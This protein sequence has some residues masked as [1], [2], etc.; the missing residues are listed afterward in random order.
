MAFEMEIYPA[1]GVLGMS[2]AGEFCDVVFTTLFF[3]ET[4]MDSRQPKSCGQRSLDQHLEV[5]MFEFIRNQARRIQQQRHIKRGARARQK[6][7][8]MSIESLEGRQLLSAAHLGHRGRLVHELQFSELPSAIQAGLT[9]D[10]S[11]HSVA[12]PVDTDDVIL[13]NANGVETYS[14]VVNSTGA[15]TRLTVDQDGAEVT[16][17]TTST[18]TYA[19]LKTSDATAA[20]EI[21]SIATAKNLTAPA[22]GKTVFVVTKSDGSVTYSMRLTRTATSKHKARKILVSVDAD[23]NPVGNQDVPF[24]VLSSTIQAG[25]NANLPTGATALAA[26][27]TQDVSVQTIDGITLYTTN[28][29]VDSTTTPVTVK[30]DGSV[31]ALPTH[32]TTTYA[33]LTTSDATAATEIQTLATAEGAGTIDTTSTVD[34]YTEATGT[35]LYSVTVTANDATTTNTYDLTIT[36]D[37]AGN[38]TTLPGRGFDHGI[39]R[40]GF[41]GRFF[42][43]ANEGAGGGGCPGMSGGDSG[44]NSGG[45]SGSS[46][47]TTTTT[48][49]RTISLLSRRFF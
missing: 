47:S 27:A 22:D 21:A 49:S 30:I 34:V 16:S 23:G 26:D 31:G 29:T 10:A 40:G 3:T 4:D 43:G 6:A 12:A 44:S 46:G 7:I 28:F 14:L 8:S 24:S 2:M 33:D 41:D 37:A 45:D 48:S 36:V 15:T 42:A 32:T 39:G 18:T 1:A 5:R 9:Q 11:D 17:P 38:P 13:G 35:V 20:T 19:D 25:I